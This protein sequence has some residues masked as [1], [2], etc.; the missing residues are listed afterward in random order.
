MNFQIAFI[1]CDCNHWLRILELTGDTGNDY[2][3]NLIRNHELIVT[4]PEKF[5][6]VTRWC[7]MSDPSLMQ[8][9][10]LV[11]IDEVHML[12]DEDRGHVLEAVVSRL[13]TAG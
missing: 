1:H 7:C 3:L 10:K 5:D 6:S 4:T 11:M 2:K 12:N 9:F 13:K 8:T